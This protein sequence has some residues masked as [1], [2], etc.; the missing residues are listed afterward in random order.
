MAVAKGIA[1]EPVR[2]GKKEDV[3]Q[4]SQSTLMWRRFLENRLSV[5][6]GLVLI[7]MYVVAAFAPF[8]SPNNYDQLD[9]DRQLSPPTAIYFVGGQPVVCGLE[10]VLNQETFTFV[11]SPDCT[12]VYPVHFLY[13]GWEYNL[14]GIQSGVHLFGVDPPQKIYLFGADSLGRDIFSRV[15]EGSRISLTIGLIGV[16]FSV[17]IGSVLGTT[18]GYLGGFAD[19]L[20]QRIIEILQSMPT[21][22]LWMAFAAALPT[23]MSVVQR[24]FLITIILSLIT[25]TGLARQVRAK[26]MAYRTLDYT[27]AARLAGASHMQIILSHMLPN[28]VSHIIVVA[29]LAV[30][31]T[32]LGE[33]ALSFLGLGMLPPAVSWG[34]LLR[35][36]Q[37]LD[38]V[39]R[40]L[41]LL[42]PAVP[43]IVAVTCFQFLGDGMRDA[44][45][46]YS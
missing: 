29:A 14:F 13:R 18:S 4:V 22:P 15:L 2:A 6:G 24:Y 37:Q 8:L 40:N 3:G 10:Q 23:T 5:V 32:I 28:A 34:V 11:Y 39:V 7:S 36:A 25:W 44:A 21:L 26:V 9:S 31:A 1:I 20:I 19:N 45:D 12:K 30:P 35:D 41:W 33:T 38:A 46:P 43:V 16:A 27:H 42:I 17:V